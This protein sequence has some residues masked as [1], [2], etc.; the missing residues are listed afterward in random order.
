[1]G[2]SET[3]FVSLGLVQELEL[4]TRTHPHPY[5]LKWL[6]NKASGSVGKQSLITLAIGSYQDQ[7]LYDVLDM[8]SC[9]ILLERS[10]QYVRMVKHDGYTN[11]YTLKHEGKLKD[12]IPVPPHRVIPPPKNRQPIHL[13]NRK[14]YIK[15][16][17]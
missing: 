15:E 12:L 2:G 10:W 16:L 8:D 4:S 5:K 14:N 9:H 17:N 7:V 1:M 13:I 3:N 6:D 11:N